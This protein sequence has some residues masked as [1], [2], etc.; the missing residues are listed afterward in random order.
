V[1]ILLDCR[2]LIVTQEDAG[3]LEAAGVSFAYLCH[4]EETGRIMTVPVN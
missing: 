2:N 1:A 3:R 4:H